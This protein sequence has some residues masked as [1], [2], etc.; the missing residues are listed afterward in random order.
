MRRA[1]S[2]AVPPSPAAKASRKR[3]GTISFGRRAVAAD[4]QI[5]VRRRAARI[6]GA[7]RDSA[8]TV[9]AIFA[10]AAV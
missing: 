5:F 9:E 6:A 1:R 7:I 3:L 8:F 4:Q 10:R 2:R